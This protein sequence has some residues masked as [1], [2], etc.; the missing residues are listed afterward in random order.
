MPDSTEETTIWACPQCGKR[1]RVP[2]RLKPPA[3]CRECKQ[4]TALAHV[5]PVP[6]IE[7]TKP[8]AARPV[9]SEILDVEFVVV[10]Q[11]RKGLS[12]LWPVQ[13][14]WLAAII[15]LSLAWSVWPTP[16]EYSTSV[17]E[18]EL[19]VTR[20]S[21]ITG[22]S[23]TRY[24][25]GWDKPGDLFAYRKVGNLE[26]RTSKVSGREEVFA[27][28]KW[29]TRDLH[30]KA[31]AE[32]SLIQVERN[33]QMAAIKYESTERLNAARAPRSLSA[34][35][36]ASIEVTVTQIGNGAILWCDFY[37]KLPFDIT[38]NSV[39]FEGNLLDG[40][41][42]DRVVD[43]STNIRQRFLAENYSISVI[44]GAKGHVTATAI[45]GTTGRR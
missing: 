43:V 7:V 28:G 30:A 42:F 25:T 33:R 44:R 37:N 2:S 31:H 17:V 24:L 6:T 11:T 36:L 10:P 20:T 12:P 19:I 4:R 40:K 34:S 21:R 15:A 26:Y 13:G 45:S 14:R 16:Y 8:K 9:E 1:F 18:G 35:E 5:E 22:L 32:I 27:F 23:Q 39:R 38:L 41:R 3:K 29:M